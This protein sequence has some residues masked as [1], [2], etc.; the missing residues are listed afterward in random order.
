MITVPDA[1][2]LEDRIVTAI[3][4]YNATAPVFSC[5]WIMQLVAFRLAAGVGATAQ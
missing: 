1:N 2:I 3:G 4:T 5:D